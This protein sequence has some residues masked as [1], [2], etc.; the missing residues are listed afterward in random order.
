MLDMYPNEISM[1]KVV[2]GSSKT[3]HVGETHGVNSNEDGCGDHLNWMSTWAVSSTVYG[4][5]A[6]NVGSDWNTGCNFRSYHGGGSFFLFVDGSVHYLNEA[7]DLWAFGYLG[8][9]NDGQVIPSY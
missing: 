6:R 9:R 7:I 4:I 8:D 3:L 2:D 1:K 5:N